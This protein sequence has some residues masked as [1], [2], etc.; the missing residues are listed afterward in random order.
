MKKSN[1]KYVGVDSCPGGWISIGLGDDSSFDAKVF[2]EFSDLLYYYTDATHILVDIPIGL[3]YEGHDEHE[4]GRQ[5]DRLAKDLLGSYE[6]RVFD[7]PCRYLVHKAAGIYRHDHSISHR[8]R[9]AK[10]ECIAKRHMNQKSVVIRPQTFS[11][12][13]KIEEVDLAMSESRPD[14][15]MRVREV[16]P[17]ICF[18][19][20]NDRNAMAFS[21]SSKS[22]AFRR[23]AIRERMDVLRRH[24]GTQAH[25]I[26][27]YARSKFPFATSVKDDDI[28]DGLIVAVTAKLGCQEGNNFETLPEDRPRN[29][30]SL[31]M[32]MVYVQAKASTL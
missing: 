11:I 21:K 22:T 18:W 32:E 5:C 25:T 7:I 9:Y 17:E 16:H 1:S 30:R 12:I 14:E 2:A 26:F 19:A 29:C 15:S 6:Q 20:L 31:P 23:K 13:P 10:A 28:T 3:P 27:T 8:E 4:T 24:L